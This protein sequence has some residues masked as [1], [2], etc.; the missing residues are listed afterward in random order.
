MFTFI[1][2][3]GEWF[4]L[5]LGSSGNRP[6]PLQSYLKSV[7]AHLKGKKGVPGLPVWTPAPLSELGFCGGG[8]PGENWRL[9]ALLCLAGLPRSP[10]CWESKGLQKPFCGARTL[11]RSPVLC[12]PQPPALPPSCL[13]RQGP[14][15]RSCRHRGDHLGPPCPGL[16]DERAGHLAEVGGPSLTDL[17]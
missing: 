2:I 14:E 11:T 8:Q 7:I 5:G 3:G 1:I 12:L 15:P 17:R 9:Q 4:R 16:C 13:R 10:C 6:F